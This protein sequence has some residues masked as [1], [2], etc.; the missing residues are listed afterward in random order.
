MTLIARLVRSEMLEV[1][2]ADY[3]KFARARGLSDRSIHFGHALRNTLVPVMTVTGLQL[4]G[5][6]AFSIV[7]ETVFSWP[8]IGQLFIQSVQSADIPVMSTYLVMIGLMFVT[9]NLCVDML[10]FLVDPRIRI[11]GRNQ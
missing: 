5:I 4:G 2:R 6:I 3:I 9:I 1:L 8:G 10:Y 11:A 7:T